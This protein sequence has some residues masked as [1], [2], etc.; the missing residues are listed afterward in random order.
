MDALIQTWYHNHGHD[1][2]YRPVKAC[3]TFH[4]NYHQD[5]LAFQRDGERYVDLGL[6]NLIHGVNN[7][8]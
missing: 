2:P 7:H 1:S 4:H 5:M 6:N 3:Q 8:P